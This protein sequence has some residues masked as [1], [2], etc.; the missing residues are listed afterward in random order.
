MLPYRLTQVLLVS[1]FATLWV[2]EAAWGQTETSN[3]ASPDEVSARLQALVQ[4]GPR[5]NVLNRHVHD[6]YAARDFQPVWN[7][8][9]HIS[10]LVAA[11]HGLDDDGLIPADYR[12]DA[13]AQ[14]WQ[15]I[16][17]RNSDAL[18]RVDLGATR[19]FLRA[20]RYLHLGKVDPT[21]VDSDWEIP[22]PGFAP[23]MA[24]LSRAVEA[25]DIEGAFDR[26][27][28]DYP[29]YQRLR[30]GLGRYR[31]IE[32]AGGWPQVPAR[33][34]PL[35]PGDR[36]PDVALLR[37]R[38]GV[39]GQPE[40]LVA[41]ADYYREEHAGL[42]LDVPEAKRYDAALADAVRRFQ[43]RHLLE[44]DGVVGPQ[45]RAALNVGVSRR[46]DQ[47]RVNLERARWMLHDL[48]DS[49]VLVDIAGYELRYFLPGD[50][51]WQ[52][53]IVVGQPYRTTPTLRSEI[54]RLTFN[55]TWTV[56]PTIFREDKLPKIREDLEYLKRKNLAVIDMQGRHLDPQEVDWQNPGAIMLRQAAG[57]QNPLGR[58]VIRFPNRHSVYLHDTPSQH[59]FDNPQRAVSSGCIRVENA[60]QFVRLLLD[61]NRRWDAAAL[62][63]AV[64]SGETRTVDLSQR[65]PVILH[66]WTVDTAENGSLAFRPDIYR[67]DS[68]LL[69]ALNRPSTE[70]YD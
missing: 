40:L 15:R 6:F 11:L 16:Q 19:R 67:R 10:A 8:D 36:H 13:L 65:V 20:L 41:D 64:A 56:P 26:A 39:L 51:V 37:E 47:I 29:P 23:D 50:D 38:L 22:R 55:P 59:L 1:L 69:L 18:A 27:R 2:A 42:I 52:T 54:T 62:Q 43:R 14:A 48:P 34:A 49:F 35:R 7:D 3:G 58:V 66:Y 28:P 5:D 45:T 9:R 68:D 4:D 31:A 46:I 60:M 61:D 12:P 53:R 44:D 63:Q 21:A 30:E 24:A 25:G 33:E 17:D 32:A 57:G 70:N